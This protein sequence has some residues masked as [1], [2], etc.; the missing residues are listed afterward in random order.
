[1]TSLETHLSNANAAW[2]NFAVNFYRSN[3]AKCH[4]GLVT[5]IKQ[6]NNSEGTFK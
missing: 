5:I 1:M 3:W 6:I 2:T 4:K